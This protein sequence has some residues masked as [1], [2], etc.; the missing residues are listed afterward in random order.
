M[1]RPS[2]SDIT[3]DHEIAQIARDTWLTATPA[4]VLP[5]TVSKL[6]KLLE[7]DH[8]SDFSLLLLE[9]L[10]ALERYLWP[11]YTQDASNQ[12]VLLLALLVNVKRRERLPTWPIFTS[13]PDEFSDFFRRIVHLSIDQSLLTSLRTHL[14]VFIVGAYQSLDHGI[15]RK[16]CAPLV[17]IGI[18]HNIHTDAVREKHLAKSTQLQKAWRA[19]GKKFDNADAAGQAR[20]RFERSWL[21]TLLSQFLDKLYETSTKAD[22]KSENMLFCERFL[23]LLSD[24]QSQLPTR[25]YVNTLLQDMNTLPAIALSPMHQDERSIREMYGLLSHY[26]LFPLDDQTGRQ[27]SRQEYEETQNAD[28]G[29]LQKVAMKLQSEKLKILYLTNFGALSQRQ[30]LEGHIEGLTDAELLELCQELGLRT[31]EY[32]EKTLLVRDRAFLTECLVSTVERKTY[33]TEQ[34]RP[35][36]VLPTEEVLYDQSMLATDEQDQS[37]PLAIPKLNLQYLT[38]G[39]FLWRSFVLYRHEAFYEIRKHLEDTIKRLQPRRGGGIT[40]FDGF[41]RMAIPIA[42]PAIIETQP[43]RVGETAPA[44]VKVEIILDVSRLQPGLRREWESLRQDDTVFLLALHPEDTAMKLTNGNGYHSPAEKLGLK[45]VRTADVISVLDENGRVLRH[46]HEVQDHI[47]GMARPKQRRLLLRL[48][49]AAYQADKERA[50]A[51]KG[52]IYD[53]INL[54]VRRRSR[55]NNFRPVLESI[56][57]LALSDTP[58]PA[59]LQEVFLGFGDP[60]SASYKR[61]SNKLKSVDYRDTFLDWQ[62]LIE[63]LPGK[64]LEPDPKFDSIFPPPYVL[65]ATSSQPAPPPPK[66]GKKRRRDQPDGP[67]PVPTAETFRVSTYNPPNMGPYPTDAPKLNGV[68]FTPT[69]VE[70]VTSGTQPGLTLIVGPP[71]TGKTDVATQIINNV[72]HD[73]PQQRTLL[74]AHSNQALNQLFQKIVALDID[75]R[76]LLRLGHGEEELTTEASFSKA[77]RVE[78]FLERGGYYLVE[79]QRLAGSIGAP[80]A[81]GSSCETAEYFDQVYVQPRWMRFW[82]TAK[83]EEISLDDL[84]TAFPFHAFFANTPGPLFPENASK[85][86]II[87][88][89]Q[90]CERHMR[91]IFDELADI[92]PF[93]ILRAQKDKSNYLLVKEARIIA[94]TS[95]HAAIRRQEI[96]A[97]GFHY[98]NVVMEEAAQITEVENFIPFVLQKPRVEDGKAPENPLQ[99]IVLVGDHLQ[100]SPVIQN[101]ALKTYANLEQSLFQRLIRL[102]V[103]HILLDAQGRSRPSLANLYKWRYPTLQ[104]LPITTTSPEFVAANAGFRY[105]YQ[106]VEVPDYKGQG[107]SEPSPH[108]LQNLGEAEYAVAL[109]QYMRLLGYPAERITILTAY[110]GQRALIK[111]VLNHRCKNNRLFGLPGWVGTID[112]YQGE[113]NDYVILSLVRTKSPGYLRDLRR[114]TV[115]LSR[116]RL[117]LYVLGRKEVFESS[118]E[119]REAFAPLFERGTKLEVVMNEMYPTERTID[120]EVKKKDIAQM[121]GVEHL[122]QYVFE[123]TKAKVEALKQSGGFLPPAAQSS[124]GRMEEDEEGEDDEDGAEVVGGEIDGEDE[125]EDEV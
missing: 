48:D 91:R 74:I 31:S 17:S 73:F 61:L 7:D 22:T 92:R 78:S 44:E 32:P 115:A 53:S 65:E 25:R 93:E 118:L 60:S 100:N 34:L 21:H 105:D 1:A 125:M 87:D 117:G 71:G 13:T 33:Y 43:P 5:A 103:P 54:V 69:Q 75:E 6:W 116:A 15:V 27:L 88:V 95:T 50:D 90:G 82:E 120:E 79:V 36:R 16:E 121:D 52:D 30:E 58:I 12:H 99:R 112:K 29:K 70:A 111:D 66:S 55:E 72:Y 57:Q 68:R 14:L 119:L 97:L 45:A 124:K 110:A 86:Q 11:G 122:G 28:I 46:N 59:W 56:K 39:D 24:L 98:D 40:R 4:S 9:Q 89:V 106:F 10:Q 62:H 85:E 19:A 104:N 2:I 123:M 76:H 8:F 84:V 35:L 64:T 96:A 23:E 77:G 108:F 101:N 114:L 20:L 42:K 83:S 38:V 37:R 102:G 26:T 113:Q 107:E 18:W 3:G 109:Y 63:A 67:D 41:S 51:N 47:D 94:M 80:G 81:H 49:A